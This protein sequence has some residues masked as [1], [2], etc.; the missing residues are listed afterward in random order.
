MSAVVVAITLLLSTG[1]MVIPAAAAELRVTGFLD[2]IIPRLES[3]NSSGHLRH[4]AK[5][6]SGDVRASRA[7]LFFN[8]L[9]SDDVRG[10]FALEM[11]NTYGAPARNPYWRALCHRYGCLRE[12]TVWVPES[13]LMLIT[14]SSNNSMWISA[15]SL[16]V[17]NRW[18]VGGLPVDATPLHSNLLY[19][20][21]RR[22]R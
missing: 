4:G 7:R 2:N 14:L 18:R 16:P 1:V 5:R 17:G 22:R 6:R 15:S 10:V 9:A 11:D 19:D 21:G 12:R 13:G 20:D 3:N 8:F